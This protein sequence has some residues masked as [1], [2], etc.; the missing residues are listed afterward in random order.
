ME[1]APGIP[2]KI[3]KCVGRN[4]MKEK[5]SNIATGFFLPQVSIERKKGE[6]RTFA[7]K[8]ILKTLQNCLHPFKIGWKKSNSSLWRFWIKKVKSQKCVIQKNRFGVLKFFKSFISYLF[9]WECVW[10]FII[11]RLMSYKTKYEYKTRK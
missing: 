11:Q 7:L 8:I 9:S 5:Q 1:M 4:F 6:L 10:N 3:S 2:H